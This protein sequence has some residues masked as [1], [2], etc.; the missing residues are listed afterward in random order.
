MDQDT[1][2]TGRL[3][4]E[5]GERVQRARQQRQMSAQALADRCAELGMTM[6]RSVIAKL[7]RGLRQGVSLAEV[8]VLARAL[9][10]PPLQLMLPIGAE[11]ST[12]VLP[13]VAA[14]TWQAV[15]WLEGREAFPADRSQEQSTSAATTAW[16]DRAAPVRLWRAHAVAASRWRQLVWQA[17]GLR[18]DAAR[19]WHAVDE[20]RQA[21][22]DPAAGEADRVLAPSR[23]SAVTARAQELMRRA[24]LREQQ[25][26]RAEEDL[27]ELRQQ[28]RRSGITPPSLGG[29][30]ALEHLDT[31]PPVAELERVLARRLAEADRK[32]REGG[33]IDVD[34]DKADDYAGT[35]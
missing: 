12:E 19:H 26:L 2:W 6:D 14:D 17:D 32:N 3:T 35:M 5:V 16:M 28:M 30:L 8:L 4:R 1:G 24:N 18:Q 21:Q 31:D 22:H 11:A 7:E 15:E 13:G 33:A 27:R 25:A 10:V 23:A 29:E 9:G 34:P 20:L